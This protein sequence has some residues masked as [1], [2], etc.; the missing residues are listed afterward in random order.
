ML[1]TLLFNGRRHDGTF[2]FAP[3]SS[4]CTLVPLFNNTAQ[5]NH[6]PMIIRLTAAFISCTLIANAALALSPEEEMLQTYGSEDMI[7]I[8][9]GQE[10]LIYAAPAVASVITAKEIANMGATD[11]DEALETVPGL[12]VAVDSLSYNPIYTFRG[13]YSKFNPQVLVLINGIPITN[14]YQG[15]RNS[16]WGG[17]PV[18]MISRIEVIR[19]PGSALYG[20]DAFA[21][22]INVITKNYD[23]I[24][25]T[26]VGV[27]A[28]SFDTQDLWALSSTQWHDYK[29]AWGVELHDTDGHKKIIDS[30]AQ[31]GFDVLAATDASLAPSSLSLSRENLDARLDVS[32]GLWRWRTGLQLRQ[33]FGLGAGAANALDQTGRYRSQRTNTDITYENKALSEDTQLNFEISYLNTTMEI[34]KNTMLFPSGTNLGS[35]AFPFGVSGNP[36]VYEH[37]IK[38]QPMLTLTQLDQHTISLGVGGKF[39]ELYKVRETKNF[40]SATFAPLN[41]DGALVDVS[42]TP[43]AF[44]PEISRTNYYIFTQDIWRIANDW[45]LTSGVRYDHYSDFGETFNPR[46]ALVWNARYDISTKIL[47]GQAFRSPAFAD[48][49]AV[50]NP[51]FLGNP[52]I[53]PETLKSLELAIDYHPNEDLRTTMSVFKY[54]WV[55]IITYVKDQNAPTIRA[56]NFGEQTGHGIELE[57]DW[58]INKQFKVIGNISI[59]KSTDEISHQD[60]GNAPSRDFYLRGEWEPTNRIRANLQSTWIQDR[61]RPVGDARPAIDD[62]N[63]IDFNLNRTTN[64]K[65]WQYGLSIKNISDTDVREPATPDINN[66]LPLA[67][68]S[69]WLE[70][71]YFPDG[72]N[73]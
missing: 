60:P 37:H 50:N 41:N 14:S 72:K 58:S 57:T 52:K 25:G 54:Q 47:Y 67:G 61:D 2:I 59:Q 8:A 7:R 24:K 56:Q 69:F 19:G 65:Y 27:R 15:N 9:T 53:N 4:L 63:T 13:V 16:M 12:H 21:G 17:M 5:F 40:E 31:S 42:D 62:Y 36:E 39:D 49:S 70:L 43:L 38:I 10:Q 45:E 68:R 26:E 66:D 71:S 11:L 3:L 48:T 20:A 18:E 6:R 30:D 51:V 29:I 33:D 22:V 1:S 23:D 32:K 35:G 46:L 55:D 44:I 73:L 34:E 28:G 64:D